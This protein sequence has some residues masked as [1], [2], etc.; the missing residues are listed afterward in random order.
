MGFLLFR[1]DMESCRWCPGAQ[2]GHL[3]RDPSP[4]AGIQFVNAVGWVSNMF[5]LNSIT[6]QRINSGIHSSCICGQHRPAKYWLSVQQIKF[7]KL[8]PIRRRRHWIWQQLFIFA[9]QSEHKKY[10]SANLL[11]ITLRWLLSFS[12]DLKFKM[13]WQR[14]RSQSLP[15]RTLVR[16]FQQR[17]RV[18]KKR[19]HPKH[20]VFWLK[21]TYVVT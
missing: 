20:V 8:L 13:W 12:V 14:Q 6:L 15:C 7:F 11:P 4:I 18:F 5:F 3:I 1:C 10:V 21:F 17:H 16:T 19:K 9:K 2:S